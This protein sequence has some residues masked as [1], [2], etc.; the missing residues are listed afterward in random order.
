MVN[1]TFQEECLP[2]LLALPGILPRERWIRPSLRG[3]TKRVRGHVRSD[4]SK[5]YPRQAES[6]RFLFG[7]ACPQRFAIPILRGLSHE[8]GPAP[9]RAK[10]MFLGGVE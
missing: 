3:I 1:Q 4:K 2:P 8:I 7:A 5:V 6:H 10:D 9:R